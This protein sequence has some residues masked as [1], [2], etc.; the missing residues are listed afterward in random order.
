MPSPSEGKNCCKHPDPKAHISKR[1]PCLLE[2][3]LLV[4]KESYAA[5]LLVNKE[6]YAASKSIIYISSKQ[7]RGRSIARIESQFHRRKE[8]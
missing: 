4:N 8:K 3:M 1:D 5:M 2:A 7:A 6:S